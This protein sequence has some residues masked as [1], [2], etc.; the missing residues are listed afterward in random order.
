MPSYQNAAIEAGL[1]SAA[2]VASEDPGRLAPELRTKAKLSRHAAFTRHSVSCHRRCRRRT[3]NRPLRSCLPRMS[4]SEL[5]LTAEP[6]R[7]CMRSMQARC[8]MAALS[9]HDHS[10]GLGCHG[11]NCC[12]YRCAGKQ[13]AKILCS[14]RP[15]RESGAVDTLSCSVD[16][17]T[18]LAGL[19]VHQ[20]C[21]E[22]DMPYGGK[23]PAGSS[24]S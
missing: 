7:S 8:T 6:L 16:T 10:P 1:F 5:R 17:A 2:W 12:N 14:P 19:A 23:G 22:G 24:G 18:G 9:A 3:G 15:R 4:F 21:H 20:R 13:L 11:C